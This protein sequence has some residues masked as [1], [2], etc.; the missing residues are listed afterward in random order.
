MTNGE[1]EW[2]RRRW[3]ACLKALGEAPSEEQLL[4]SAWIQR[5]N[6]PVDDLSLE[7]FKK[8]VSD[9]FRELSISDVISNDIETK[10]RYAEVNRNNRRYVDATF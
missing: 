10:N 3:D 4:R 9:A 8:I 2:M 1:R 5:A 7:A 6:S